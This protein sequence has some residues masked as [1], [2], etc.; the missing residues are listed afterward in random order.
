MHFMHDADRGCLGKF[1]ICQA[2]AGW[3]V[4]LFST[5]EQFYR[6][7]TLVLEAGGFSRVLD[8]GCFI[9]QIVIQ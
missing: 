4:P 6:Q 7:T 8:A 5:P 1:S 2:R 9:G 3:G